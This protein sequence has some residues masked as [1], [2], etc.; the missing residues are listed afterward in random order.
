MAMTTQPES[1]APA[2]AGRLI[3]LEKLPSPRLQLT[4][5]EQER[6]ADGY[7]LRCDYELVFPLREIDIRRETDAGDVAEFRASLGCMRT[8]RRKHGLVDFDRGEIE[9][10]YRD[11][12]HICWDSQTLNLPAFV[13]CGTQAMR[14]ERR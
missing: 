13:V 8:Q 4:W 11:G 7:D 12:A 10:P 9:T 1:P 2:E 5:I 6:D 3:P 14:I